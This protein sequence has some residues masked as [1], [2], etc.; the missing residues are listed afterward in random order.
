MATTV[1]FDDG[2]VT[3]KDTE[4]ALDAGNVDLIDFSGE[5]E[6]FRRHEIEMEGG[7]HIGPIDFNR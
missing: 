2:R 3:G 5:S 1:R 4:V 6:L 7:G